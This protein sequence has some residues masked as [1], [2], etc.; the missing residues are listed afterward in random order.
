MAKFLKDLKFNEEARAKLLK[1]INIVAEAVGSTLGPLGRNVAVDTYRDVDLPPTVLHDGVSVARAINVPD[2]FEDQ[3]V[4]L[5]KTAALKTNETAGDGTTTSTILAQAIVNEAFKV[6][7]AGNNPMV[8]KQEIEAGLKLVLAELKKLAKP[9]STDEEIVQVATISS[10]DS[11]LGQIVAEA[12]KQ[13]GKDGV[14]SVEE[15]SGFETT[16]EYKQGMEIDRGYLSPYFVTE[17]KSVEAIIENPYILLTDKKLN[18]AHEV[19]PF[20]EKFIQETQSRDLVIFAGEVLEEA[21]AVLVANKLRGVLHVCAIQAPAFG[22]RRLDELEDIA[23]LV[24]GKVLMEDSGR[25]LDKVEVAELGRAEKI[26][27]DRDKTI[28]YG[29]AGDKGA[30]EK[31]MNDLREQIKIGNTPFDKDIKQERLA[32]LAGSVAVINVGAATK[33]EMDD[34]KERVI[35]AV[36]ATKAAIAE[37]IVAGGEITLLKLSSLG[38]GILF[39]ALKAPFKRLME[40]SGLDYAEIREKMSGSEYP[41]GIDVTDG[42][43]KHLIE[44]G[45]IDPVKVTRC[46]LE[47]ACSVALMVITT[48]VL[49]SDA[50]KEEK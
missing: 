37:G 15:G 22:G 13:I 10:A 5:L 2:Q 33:V 32:K 20:L 48:N 1:G 9:I 43:I 42:Q 19:M 26:I 3:G 12:I 25:G 35:D 17:D 44:A 23:T 8:L 49:I 45:I 14:V 4:R 46:A 31:R 16:V 41:Q 21:M 50:F 40:N 28:I 30:I 24:G 38:K 39:D 6:I 11:S 18:W 27:A 34:K 47:N 29:G 36:A 7:A